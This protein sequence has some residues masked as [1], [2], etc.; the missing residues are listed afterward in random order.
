M[1]EET[2][3]AYEARLQDKES[4]VKLQQDR[5]KFLEEKIDLLEGELG[6]KNAVLEPSSG[7]GPVCESYKVHKGEALMDDKGVYVKDD[8]GN[9]ISVCK[10]MY[11]KKRSYLAPRKPGQSDYPNLEVYLCDK[12]SEQLLGIKE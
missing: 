8:K 10:S 7:P 2:K 11:T 9:Y 5:I 1:S 6:H 4:V 3:A 12:H